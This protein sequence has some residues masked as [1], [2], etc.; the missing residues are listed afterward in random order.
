MSREQKE[1]MFKELKDNAT[2]ADKE[3]RFSSFEAFEEKL[4]STELVAAFFGAVWCKNTQK[5]T[6][7]YLEAQKMVDAQIHDNRFY[8]TKVECTTDDEV[9]CTKKYN[10]TGYPTLNIYRKGKILEEY[11]GGPDSGELWQ[12]LEEVYRNFTDPAHIPNRPK[13]DRVTTLHQVTASSFK[14]D[15]DSTSFSLFPAFGL[16]LFLVTGTILFRKAKQPRNRYTTL[17]RYA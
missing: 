4:K 2:K 16:L 5:F 1:A 9:T 12:Y 11:P 6:P 15:N 3:I 10:V 13:V 8:L 17:P 14:V 7:A